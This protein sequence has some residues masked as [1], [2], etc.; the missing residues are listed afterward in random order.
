M[1]L[2]GIVPGWILGGFRYALP[3][4]P[5]ETEHF[6]Y[7]V[8]SSP[9]DP[10]MFRMERSISVAEFLID[11]AW[12]V[13]MSRPTQPETTNRRIVSWVVLWMVGIPIPIIILLWF[14]MPSHLVH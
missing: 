11:A 7:P 12:R 4:N 6:E 5:T 2:L 3:E 8:R 14:F 10:E 1:G 9:L 13:V